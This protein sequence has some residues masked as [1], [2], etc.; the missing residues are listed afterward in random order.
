MK[1][2]LPWAVTFFCFIGAV[3][4]CIVFFYE[5][6]MLP[7]TIPTHWTAGIGIDR[8]GDKSEIYP[9]AIIPSVAAAIICPLSVISIVK[10]KNWPAYFLNFV[11]LF[12]LIAMALAATLMISNAKR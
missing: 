6:S 9:L 11:L 2:F 5:M 12:L 3:V 1:K 10:K 7:N 4:F 8:W